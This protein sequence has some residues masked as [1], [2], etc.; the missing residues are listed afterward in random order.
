M[1]HELPENQGQC[2]DRESVFDDPQVST[3]SQTLGLTPLGEDASTHCRTDRS[4]ALAQGGQ[5][6]TWP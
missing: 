3:L 1:Q 4:R 6:E 5:E 2:H